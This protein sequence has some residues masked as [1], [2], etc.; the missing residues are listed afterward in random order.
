[1]RLCARVP[2]RGPLFRLR[3]NVVAVPPAYRL[4]FTRGLEQ[5]R[6]ELAD[7]LQHREAGF[8]GGTAQPP[9]E[10]LVDERPQRVED[11]EIVVAAHVLRGIER[12]AAGEDGQPGEQAAL[13]LVEQAVTPVE[14]RAQRALAV[15]QV[16]RA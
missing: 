8:A 11:V 9:D 10:A 16:L 3:Q 4:G 12:P 6:R 14:R 13:R 15:G 1:M 7:R 2:G 5:L